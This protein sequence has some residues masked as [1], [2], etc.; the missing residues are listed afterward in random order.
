MVTTQYR[1][2]WGS[3]VGSTCSEWARWEDFMEKAALRRQRLENTGSRRGC[4]NRTRG[5]AKDKEC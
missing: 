1:A 2:V 3:G 4:R 5:M